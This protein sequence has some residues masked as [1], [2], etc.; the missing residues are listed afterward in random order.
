MADS[1]FAGL[2]N[3]FGPLQPSVRRRL[4]RVLLAP[5]QESWDDA[6]GL[7]LRSDGLGLDL[8]RAV[9]A[10]DP[11]SLGAKRAGRSG[12]PVPR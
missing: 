4:R 11:N 2:K 5:S 9:K 1:L 7:L 12:R 3:H 8:W 10:V 6:Y